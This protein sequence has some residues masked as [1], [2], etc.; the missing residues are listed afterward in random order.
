MIVQSLEPITLTEVPLQNGK[1]L[2]CRE[3]LVLTIEKEEGLLIAEKYDLGL[4]AFAPKRE[5]LLS[6]ITGEFQ[7]VWKLYALEDPEK[8]TERA[9][10]L[11]ERLLAFFTEE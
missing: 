10:Q 6:E 1:K 9:V 4:Y 5:E 11:K 3:P 2:V 7:A 8:L